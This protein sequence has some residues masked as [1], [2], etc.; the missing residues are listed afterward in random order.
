[1]NS[2]VPFILLL[3]LFLIALSN[4]DDSL[5][6]AK[7]N[8][9]NLVCD[10]NNTEQIINKDKIKDYDESRNTFIFTNGYARSCYLEEK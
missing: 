4:E 5:N 3:I 10:I 8:E 9:Y 6:K 1:M 2:P 7:S